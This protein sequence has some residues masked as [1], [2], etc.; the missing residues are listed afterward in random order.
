MRRNSLWALDIPDLD[1]RAFQHCG[2]RKIRLYG[3]DGGGDGGGGSTGDTVGYGGAGD[4]S[5]DT[6]TVSGGYGGAGDVS[7]GYDAAA[8]AAAAQ[9][10]ADAQAAAYAQAAYEAALAEQA[11]ASA[12]QAQAAAAAQAAAE[13]QAQ[14][15]AQAAYEAAQAAAAEDAAQESAAQVVNDIAALGL[16]LPSATSGL[17]TTTTQPNTNVNVMQLIDI[18]LQQ[19]VSTYAGL[20][21]ASS[22]FSALQQQGYGYLEGINPNNPTQSIDNLMASFK[23]HTFLNENIPHIMGLLGGPIVGAVTSAAVAMSTGKSP[24]SIMGQIALSVVASLISATT[25]VRVSSQ[26]LEALSQGRIGQAAYNIGVATLSERTGLSPTAISAA[27]RGDL[28]AAVANT[29]TSSVISDIAAAFSGPLSS[30]VGSQIAK[31]DTT[32]DVS[33]TIRDAINSNEFAANLNE[34]TKS[35][36][37]SVLSANIGVPGGVENTANAINTG[38]VNTLPS[39]G[40]GG[41]DAQAS[42][43]SENLSSVEGAKAS[44]PSLPGFSDLLWGNLFNDLETYRKSTPPVPKETVDQQIADSETYATAFRNLYY[45]KGSN[46]TEQEIESILNAADPVAEANRL[47]TTEGEARDIWRAVFGS[48]P[49]EEDLQQMVGRSEAEARAQVSESLEDRSNTTIDEARDFWKTVFGTDPTEDELDSLLLASASEAD[50]LGMIQDVKDRRDAIPEGMQQYSNPANWP[51]ELKQAIAQDLASRAK[52]GT[53]ITL[54]DD[55]TYSVKTSSGKIYSFS[56][57]G[58]FLGDKGLWV[59]VTGESSDAAQ[60]VPGM[61]YADSFMNDLKPLLD[62]VPISS[63]G[64]YVP[65]TEQ[66]FLDRFGSLFSFGT[67]PPAGLGKMSV[68]GA[69]IGPQDDSF[70]LFT[71]DGPTDKQEAIQWVDNIIQSETVTEEEIQKAQELK[72]LIDQTPVAQE[73]APEPITEPETPPPPLFPEF[74]EPFNPAPEPASGPGNEPIAEPAPEPGPP[75]PPEEQPTYE[76]QTGTVIAVDPDTGKAIVQT[77]DGNTTEVTDPTLRPGDTVDVETPTQPTTPVPEPAPAPGPSEPPPVT[78]QEPPSEP[79]GEPQPVTYTQMVTAIND[80]LA[81]LQFPPGITSE[82][83]TKAIADYV[84]NNP[85]LTIEDVTNAVKAQLESMPEYVTQEEVQKAWNDLAGQTQSQIGNTESRLTEAIQAAKQVGLQGDAAL[86]AA[87]QAVASE[88]GV[89]KT[90]LLAQI[91]KSEEALRTDFATELGGVRQEI[92]NVESRLSDAIRAATES[93]LAGDQALEAAIQSVATDLGAS[94]EQI[95]AEIGK[96]EETL[97]TD[98]ASQIGQVQEQIGDVE[99]RLQ[100][101]IASAEAAGLS[102]DQA[103]TSAINSVAADLGITKTDLLGQIGKSEETLRSELEAGLGGIETQLGDVEKRIS[104]AMAAAEASGISR[105]AALGAAIDNVAADLGITR[106]DLLVQ[107]GKSEQTLRQELG[108]TETELRGEITVAQKAILDKVAQYEAAGISRDEALDRAI[109][110]VSTQLGQTATDLRGDIEAAKETLGSQIT[111]QVGGAE[112]RLQQAISDAVAAGQRGDQA[113]QTAI[114]SVATDLGVT[115]TD[116]LTQLGKTETDLRSEFGTQLGAVTE[117][118]ED[119]D[120]RLNNRIGELVTQGK[121]QYDA[122]SQA[123]RE[124]SEEQQ[125]Q[126]VKTG[127]LEQRVGTGFADIDTRIGQL[128]SQGA[129]YQEATDQALGEVGGQLTELQEAQKAEEEARKQ[130]AERQSSINLGNIATGLVGGVGGMNVLSLLGQS[131]QQAPAQEDKPQ[132]IKPFF[133]GKEQEEFISP[134]QQF[135]KSVKQTDYAQPEQEETQQDRLDQQD[136]LQE[137]E[138]PQNYFN[139]GQS[140]DV[141]DMFVPGQG[142]DDFLGFRSGG[143]VPPLMAMGGTVYH[144]GKHRTDYRHG[145]AVTGPGDGQ[146]DDIPAMLADGEYVIDAEIVAALGNGSTKAGSKILD[147]MRRAIRAHK[148]S[149]PLGSIPPKAKSPLEY[150]AEGAKMRK[151]K[152]QRSQ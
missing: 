142:M 135:L 38:Q 103:L 144:S 116:I 56:S 92:G 145:S 85:G 19:N 52:Q 70:K 134:L 47:Y 11:A 30:I 89:T 33:Q 2:N 84:Q 50:T 100:T 117:K 81:G 27:L 106:N 16:T 43:A 96:T 60:Y 127:E 104:D 28:G 149:G 48:D 9:A 36:S 118:V 21:S 26:T 124:I 86:Q 39:Y 64:N 119:L 102:R 113:L 136:E 45:Q 77:P 66:T 14:A 111:E 87:I 130:E 132:F 65:P 53:A 93:G 83:V 150:I 7:G 71:F 73:P 75:S 35:F 40:E 114:N 62:V 141:E 37:D 91:G 120:T 95:L 97:R 152:S 54:S 25:G 58:A 24:Q 105:D 41:G 69:S 79:S 94:K 10:E 6:G 74:E 49:T 147:D 122:T 59:V 99:Q 44:Q 109:L 146:S 12:A 3:G 126:G 55:G 32:R 76:T 121:S 18:A 148:R 5:T 29:V 1:P 123:L 31:S 128:M 80:A 42:L 63:G 107:I 138:M 17:S 68:F 143:L 98:F 108:E 129:S 78:P 101:A 112:N 8:A 125:R 23:T 57:D 67:E 82:D 88:L 140:S 15:E 72:T 133:T 151:S 90:D 4:V 137:Q 34:A 51:S 61:E 115:K 131:S 13:A 139:Y 46:L 110:D 20:N 22:I